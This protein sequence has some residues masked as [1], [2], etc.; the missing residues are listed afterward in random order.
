MS[1]HSDPLQHSGALPT[2]G[3][4]AA[5]QRRW[6]L[7]VLAA[8]SASR[9]IYLG[10]FGVRFDAIPLADY[11][12]FVDE[13]LLKT[14]LL[15][16]VYYLRDQ[17]PLFNLGVGVLLKLFPRHFELACQ[18]LALAGGGLLAASLFVLMLR[19]GVAPALAAACTSAFAIHPTTVLL[20]N[21]LMYEYPIACLLT[22]MALLLHR[23]LSRG[24]R[25]DVFGFFAL[26]AAL[27]LTRGTF[28]AA[29]FTAVTVGVCFVVR[30]LRNVGPLPSTPGAALPP[31]L[32][33][34]PPV[35]P[36][37][38]RTLLAAVLPGLLVA[39]F[40]AKN[41]LLFGESLSGEVYRKLNLY[42]MTADALRP[43]LHDD[44]LRDGRLSPVSKIDFYT[45]R[46]PDYAQWL[47]PLR[48]TGIPLL[49]NESKASGRANW[50]HQSWPRIADLYNR[51]AQY[52]MEHYPSV[53]WYNVWGNLERYFV[54]AW[55]TYPFNRGAH[56]NASKLE[57][58]LDFC[59]RWL[60]GQVD[61]AR[62]GWLN[63]LGLLAALLFGLLYVTMP[64]GPRDSPDAARRCPR[65]AAGRAVVA[66][67]LF[68][69]AYVAAVTILFSHGDH[70]RYR[71][72]LMPFYAALLAL[73][74]T[75]L[76][77]QTGR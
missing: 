33:G 18:V 56:S 19:L 55:Q 13:E 59:D 48:P 26:A 1:G 38:R 25:R 49:D 75:R 39:A 16:S 70:N 8:F 76:S 17:P 37:V 67:M 36:G 51:D 62:P 4:A 28:H 77:R 30:R 42:M 29:W 74:A 11:F 54:P 31:A 53:Y 71:F 61:Y 65:G 22:P 50:H 14:R 34:K 43:D 63:V 58:S 2:R 41:A 7:V 60:S 47:P 46:P 57:H 52:V 35:A 21:W 72:P 45:A 44:L 5:A 6:L 69:I 23:S 15:E 66:F 68:N 9:L 40:Y 3:P 32:A 20:E 24:R 27:V 10:W 12:Q 64:S 73:L